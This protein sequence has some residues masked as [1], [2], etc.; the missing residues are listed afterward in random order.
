MTMTQAQDTQNVMNVKLKGV[1]LQVI[2]FIVMSVPIFCAKLAVK[3]VKSME[4]SL[5]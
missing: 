5:R 4:K 1:L 3:I 2:F